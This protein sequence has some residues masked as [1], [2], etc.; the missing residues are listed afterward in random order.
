MLRFCRNWK[1]YKPANYCFSSA[2]DISFYL[3]KIFFQM[4]LVS[5][6]ILSG[7]FAPVNAMREMKMGINLRGIF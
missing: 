7:F 4:A 6:R 2:P 1:I 5:L 3:E